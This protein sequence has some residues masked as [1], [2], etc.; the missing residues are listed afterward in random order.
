MSHLRSC[1]MLMGQK[2]GVPRDVIIARVAAL[3]GVDITRPGSKVE[4]QQAVRA[5]VLIKEAG[6]TET[7]SGP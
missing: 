4:I 6:P 2:Y 5:L 1:A 3:C 7:T